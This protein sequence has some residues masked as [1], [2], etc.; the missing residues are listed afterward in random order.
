MFEDTIFEINKKQNFPR[1]LKLKGMTGL[2]KKQAI[3]AGIKDDD[4]VIVTISVI[5]ANHEQTPAHYSFEKIIGDPVSYLLKR[6]YDSEE[7]SEDRLEGLPS[8][9]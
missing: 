2:M 6:L 8:A 9:D 4:L 1:I 7:K 5:Y 3:E